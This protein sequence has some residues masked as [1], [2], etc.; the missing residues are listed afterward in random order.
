MFLPRQILQKEAHSLGLMITKIDIV[1]LNGIRL[2][3]S[4]FLWGGGGGRGGGWKLTLKD[5]WSR[6]VGGD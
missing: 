5:A 2:L 3:R 1:R 4:K 6:E